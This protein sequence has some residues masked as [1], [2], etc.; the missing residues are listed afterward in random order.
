MEVSLCRSQDS[1]SSRSVPQAASRVVSGRDGPLALLGSPCAAD[2]AERH[3]SFVALRMLDAFGAWWVTAECQV[4][5]ARPVNDPH[6]D[7]DV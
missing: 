3:G 2:G 1:F 5:H 4:P 7:T 6:T